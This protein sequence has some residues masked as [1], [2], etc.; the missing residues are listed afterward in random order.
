M[1]DGWNKTTDLLVV[2]RTGWVHFLC[3]SS[4][5]RPAQNCVWLVPYQITSFSFCCSRCCHRPWTIWRTQ[6]RPDGPWQKDPVRRVFRRSFKCSSQTQRTCF[7]W[8]SRTT[9]QCWRNRYLLESLHS[10][11]GSVRGL[12]SL[13]KSWIWLHQIQGL[14]ILEFYK[15]VLKSLEFNCG[16]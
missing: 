12:E 5:T 16:Q 2:V 4:E 11:A 9:C 1:S 15:E 6:Y 7:F 14:E 13:E 8:S 3:D 10:V